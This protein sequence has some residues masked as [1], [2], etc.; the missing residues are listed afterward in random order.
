M[1]GTV[2]PRTEEEFFGYME[3]QG[4]MIERRNERILNAMRMRKNLFGN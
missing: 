1:P 2:L 3:A 4:D